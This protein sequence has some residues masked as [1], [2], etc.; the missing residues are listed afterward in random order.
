MR[1]HR[2]TIAERGLFGRDAVLSNGKVQPVLC[3][4]GCAGKSFIAIWE[5][6]QRSPPVGRKR[7]LRITLAMVSRVMTRFLPD[8]ARYDFLKSDIE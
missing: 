6:F 7:D 4:M 3:G 2:V 5:H 1:T 8:A